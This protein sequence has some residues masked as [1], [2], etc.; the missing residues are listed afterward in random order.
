MAGGDDP[1]ADRPGARRESH[2]G[3]HHRARAHRRTARRFV[4]RTTAVDELPALTES[5]RTMRDLLVDR[6]PHDDAVL[7][8]YPAFAKPG[9]RV[10]GRPDWWSETA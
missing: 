2:V 4:D 5:M 8:A 3:H 1:A 10:A 7:R 6:W 9:E